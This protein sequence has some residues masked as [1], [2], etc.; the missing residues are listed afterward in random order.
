MSEP[1]KCQT[2]LT[3]I[4]SGQNVGPDLG[5]NCLKGLLRDDNVKVK[6]HRFNLNLSEPLKCQTVLTPIRSGQNVGPDLGP[7]C[8]KM[9]SVDDKVMLK[10][11]AKIQYIG[12]TATCP[13]VLSVKQ[14][15]P[16][17]G[18]DRMSGLIWVQ[19]V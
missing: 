16:L 3:P 4:R 12:S 6:I 14:F 10:F 1:L 19:I 9:L 15:G 5:P 11:N 8:L 13:Y 7:N 2:V 18:L 17:S